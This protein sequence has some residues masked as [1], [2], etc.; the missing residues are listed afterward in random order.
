MEI[1]SLI[2]LWIRGNEKRLPENPGRR[3]Q[4]NLHP[5]VIYADRLKGRI[6]K[7]VKWTAAE[8]LTEL[9]GVVAAFAEHP[10]QMH[11]QMRRQIL[12]NCGVVNL[13]HPV[14][15]V[16]DLDPLRRLPGPAAL[17]AGDRVPE[18]F[19]HDCARLLYLQTILACLDV[20]R[21]AK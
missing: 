9:P 4:D 3:R 21:D 12:A 18:V 19:H 17:P 2:L 1:F 5:L 14:I 15:V 16:F 20:F 8:E 13:T 6:E 11:N 7:Q 10:V